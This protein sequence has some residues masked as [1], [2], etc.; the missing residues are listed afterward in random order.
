[1]ASLSYIHL[2]ETRHFVASRKLPAET[3]RY[4]K[5]SLLQVASKYWEEYLCSEKSFDNVFFFANFYRI[6]RSDSKAIPH[7]CSRI[8]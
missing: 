1:M 3:G 7:P 4:Y 8:V 5:E 6:N 2:Q